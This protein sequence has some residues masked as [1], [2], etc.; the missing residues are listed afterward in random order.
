MLKPAIKP[1]VWIGVD[2]GVTGAIGWVTDADEVGVADMPALAVKD[3]RRECQPHL[4]VDIL[5]YLDQQYHVQGYAVEKTHAMPKQ[6]VSS[7]FSMGDSQGCARSVGAALG[8]RVERPT[9]QAWMK[10]MFAGR[11][12]RAKDASRA[13]VCELWP[14]AHE[15]VKLVKHHNRAEAILIAEWLRRTQ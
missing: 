14:K 6:G 10:V 15:L 13:L 7:M 11:Q 4:M 8:W 3:S 5:R 9:P 12:K 1:N 2:P